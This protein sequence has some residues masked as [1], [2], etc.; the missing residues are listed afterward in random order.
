MEAACVLDVSEK[1][2]HILPH[3]F[4]CI[5]PNL[6]VGRFRCTHPGPLGQDGC[7]G[8]LSPFP[9]AWVAPAWPG[10]SACWPACRPACACLWPACLAGCAGPSAVGCPWGGSDVTMGGFRPRSL[11]VREACVPFA[12]LRRPRF[13]GQVLG[14]GTGRAC[15]VRW[16]NPSEK[17]PAAGQG[18][19]SGVED[20]RKPWASRAQ[21]SPAEGRK[22]PIRRQAERAGGQDLRGGSRQ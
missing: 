10:L 5:R 12:R 17:Q 20:P 16:P 7:A 3:R 19:K 4:P 8:A 15:T 6:P 14:W 22:G 2:P 1:V 11:S 21:E 9:S 13:A 18:L